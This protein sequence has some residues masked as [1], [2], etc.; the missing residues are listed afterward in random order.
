[1]SVVRR[2]FGKLTGVSQ[3]FTLVE[4]YFENCINL[5]HMGLHDC[6]WSEYLEN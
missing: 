6:A 1:M 3:S 2:C 5:V 4:L